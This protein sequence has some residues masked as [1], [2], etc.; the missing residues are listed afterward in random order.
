MGLRSSVDRAL[1]SGTKGRRF[2]SCRGHDF[3][4]VV[5]LQ[6]SFLRFTT[7]K[8]GVL[9]YFPASTINHM[10]QEYG[11]YEWDDDSLTPG[12]RKEGGWHQNLYDSDGISQITHASYQQVTIMIMVMVIIL[13]TTIR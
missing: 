6:P 12:L 10:P 9:D 5:L 2:E 4:W 13:K 3:N 8:V 1:V 7:P 11:Y